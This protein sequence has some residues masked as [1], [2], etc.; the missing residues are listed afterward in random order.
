M[1]ASLFSRPIA[2]EA[3]TSYGEAG[4]TLVEMLVVIT[5]IGLI[6]GLVGPRVLNYLSESKVKTAHIQI[7]SLAA[8]MIFGVAGAV[9]D[10]LDGLQQMEIN[11]VDYVAS[12]QIQ[13]PAY[14]GGPLA[15]AR[16]VASHGAA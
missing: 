5:I 13:F 16:R 11:A 4:F 2:A 8:A 1:R 9:K 10:D 6:M 3:E 14:L 12:S 7:E 15:L